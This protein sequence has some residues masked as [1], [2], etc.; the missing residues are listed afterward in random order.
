MLDNIVILAGG[1]AVRMR[2]LTVNLP[3][4]MLTVNG[5]PFIAHQ[6]RLLRRKGI[7]RVVLCVG[8]LGEVIR[9]FVGDG[10]QFGLHVT[11]SFDGP[12]LLGTASAVRKALVQLPEHFFVTY[13]DSYLDCDYQR[14]WQAYF[15]SRK[16]AL[17][18][19]FK[20]QDRWDLSNV[21]FDGERILS[22]DKERKTPGMEHID[23]G[24]TILNRHAFEGINEA[25]P[26]D[27]AKLYQFLLEDNQLA[28]FEAG[29]RFF[30]IGSPEGLLETERHF[31][32]RRQKQ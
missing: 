15:V 27:L 9:D 16:L 14:A 19:I 13:G 17:M 23:Y 10:E 24:L 26:F 12:E 20:N 31:A 21:A 3:K 22:Y 1:Q 28:A 5:E 29:S 6:L 30:E 2:P 4:S 7:R 11:Y 25:V 8:H 18:V 32:G